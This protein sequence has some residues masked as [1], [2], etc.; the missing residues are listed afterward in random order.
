[1][2][3]K[4]Q[5]ERMLRSMAWANREV[6]AALRHG[7]A[8]QGEGVR[9]L[10]HVLAAEHIWLTRIQRRDPDLVPWAELDLDGCER[11][12]DEN[13]AGY[14][15]L[16]QGLSDMDLEESILYRNT[17]GEEF[18]SSLIDILTHVVIHGAYHRGQIA[19]ALGAAGAPGVNTDFITFT[20]I[21]EPR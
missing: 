21:V 19:K 2:A 4:A 15:A 16:I 12:A 11:L 18:N 10:A 9:L 6:L 8:A 20:R 17:K 3:M 14:A 5:L 7:S 13:A 1:M